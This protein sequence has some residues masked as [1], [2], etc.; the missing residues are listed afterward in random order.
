[1][2]LIHNIAQ[3]MGIPSHGLWCLVS[4]ESRVYLW[5]KSWILNVHVVKLTIMNMF[6]MYSYQLSQII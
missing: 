2:I 6:V 1:M 3:L 4:S 5:I